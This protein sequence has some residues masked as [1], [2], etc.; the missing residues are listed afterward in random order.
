MTAY[1]ESGLDGLL[2]DV[3]A[4]PNSAGEIEGFGYLSEGEHPILLH[5][6]D[7]TE[8]RSSESVVIT[9]GP[10]NSAPLCE[11]LT[12]ESGAASQ[13]G[14]S[15][16]FTE[17]VSDV[18][19]PSDWLS[20]IGAPTKMEISVSPHQIPPAR[21]HFF[22]DLSIDSHTITMTVTDEVGATC[23][24]FIAYNVGTPPGEHPFSCGV[25]STQG[26]GH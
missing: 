3:D 23:T 5:V 12:P 8:K 10:P 25:R 22:S 16:V 9:V 7:S 19:V 26:Y 4:V 1:W 11:I 18:D 15:V 17:N 24:D 6:E 13:V 2:S 14:D 20:V 21:F